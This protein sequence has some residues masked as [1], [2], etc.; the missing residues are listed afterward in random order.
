MAPEPNIKKR[1]QSF[2]AAQDELKALQLKCEEYLNGWKRERA[3]FLNYKKDEMERIGQ[4]VK[5]ASEEIILKLLPILD[6]FDIAEKKLPE[7]LKADVNVKGILQIKSQILEFLRNQGVEKIKVIGEPFDP[8]LHDVVEG[9]S[10]DKTSVES[11]TG[12]IIEEIQKGYRNAER[13]IRPAKVRV[14]K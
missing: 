13:V 14:T 7:N 4:L 6:N 1:E 11:E 5:Y 10:R 8:N 2:A 12:I 9:V 3:D